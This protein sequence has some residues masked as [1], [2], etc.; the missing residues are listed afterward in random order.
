MKNNTNHN[1]E[2][3]KRIDKVREY[4]DAPSCVR[5]YS[6]LILAIYA[7]LDYNIDIDCAT[8]SEVLDAFLFDVFEIKALYIM[9]KNEINS[10]KNGKK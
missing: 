8:I 3:L 1:Y 10:K 6:K 5:S 9:E 7:I 4:I 2:H